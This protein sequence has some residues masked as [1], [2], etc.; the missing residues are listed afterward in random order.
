MPAR[1]ASAEETF[2]CERATIEGGIPAAELMRR[3][4][5]RAALVIRS[6]YQ[7]STQKGALVF[8]GLLAIVAALYYLTRISP[9]LLFWA[10][11]ILTRPLGATLGDILTKPVDEGGMNLSRIASTLVIGALMVILIVLFS[12]KPERPGD[13]ERA[14]E[15]AY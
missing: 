12:R 5:N 14:G 1:V 15:S 13:L 10:A 6:K 8:A 7:K 9:T 4:G 11:F 3:A 2:F